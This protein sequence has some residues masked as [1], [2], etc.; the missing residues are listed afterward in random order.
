MMKF[1]WDEK[2][3]K[4]NIKNH[5]FDFA[6]ANEMFEGPMVVRLDGRFDY[7]EERWIGIGLVRGVICAVLVYVERGDVV[8]II[9]LRK[10]DRYE[11]EEF[12]K[13]IKN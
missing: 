9:S 4:I 3:N 13:T 7:D 5:G 8:R 6:D 11:R 10:A 12:E 1:E 2:K